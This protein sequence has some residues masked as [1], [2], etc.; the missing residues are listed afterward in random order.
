MAALSK[1]FGFLRSGNKSDRATA[2][3]FKV[4]EKVYQRKGGAS[5]SLKNAVRLYRESQKPE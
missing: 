2:A 5:T 3:A 1:P 4:G